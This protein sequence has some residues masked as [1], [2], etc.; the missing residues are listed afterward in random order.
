MKR[1]GKILWWDEKY[2]KGVIETYEGKELFFDS[3]CTSSCLTRLSAG[4]FVT[5]KIY[6]QS[7]AR[8]VE[9]I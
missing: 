2:K 5:F 3:S 9:I 4:E 8:D 1:L 6:Q 7:L